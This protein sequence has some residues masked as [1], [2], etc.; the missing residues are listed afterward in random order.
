MKTDAKFPLLSL[1]LLCA[2]AH[3]TAAPARAQRATG[4]PGA[5]TADAGRLPAP[6]PARPVADKLAP[7]GWL[8]YEIGEPARLSL[9]LPVAPVAQVDRVSVL[10]GTAGFSRS[11]MSVV[12]SGVY[13]LSYLE[14][15]PAALL[16][17]RWKREFFEGFVKEF[18]E[19]IQT[20]MKA[21]GMDVSLTTSERRAAS[22]GGLAGYEQDFSYGMVKGRVRLVFDGGT[23]Y[24]VVAVWNGLS[25]NS[26]RNAFFDS[27]KVSA[28]R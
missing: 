24:A 27:L 26:E 7:A 25:S 2:L 10:P 12:D 16:E 28:K 5:P 15:L 8:R 4:T 1:A 22:V 23:A 19:K 17:E 3:G 14:G 6:I 21:R 11:Y 20:M 18:T 13:G 9:I